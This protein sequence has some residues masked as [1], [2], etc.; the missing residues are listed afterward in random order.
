MGRRGQLHE[1]YRIERWKTR[2][3]ETV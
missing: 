2:D 1:S 3:V